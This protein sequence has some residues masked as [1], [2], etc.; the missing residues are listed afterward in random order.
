MVL[1]EEFFH[2]NASIVILAFAWLTGTQL[3]LSFFKVSKSESFKV[4]LA[5][6]SS[7]IIILFTYEFVGL[8]LEHF[9]YGDNALLFYEAATLNITMVM[10]LVILALIMIVGW[11][12]MY[13]QHF[14]EGPS[15]KNKPNKLEWLF[16]KFLVKEGYFWELFTRYL[17]FFK[18][19]R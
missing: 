11:L 14:M 16:Y 4:I 10:S 1:S 12:F 15:K 6:V 5:L 19:R 18:K 8:A 3:F 17:K 13:K 2:F 9:L 7:F